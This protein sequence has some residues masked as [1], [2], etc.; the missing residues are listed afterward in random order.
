MTTIYQRLGPNFPSDTANT[1]LP[2]SQG[3]QNRTNMMP[4]LLTPW[5]QSDV[6]NS[7]VGGYFQNPVSNIAN[8]IITL[9]NNIIKIG[10]AHV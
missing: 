2:F 3:V 10:R 1:V 6:G 8:S 9:A 4:Q 5:Q 7:N